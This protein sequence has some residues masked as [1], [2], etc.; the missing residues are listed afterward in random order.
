LAGAVLLLARRERWW[1]LFILPLVVMVS[2]FGFG[3]P[4]AVGGHS[5]I[6]PSALV[7]HRCSLRAWASVLV[8]TPSACRCQPASGSI[9]TPLITRPE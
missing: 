5:G 6:C 1:W 7:R 4:A 8:R 9:R 2:A 3:A